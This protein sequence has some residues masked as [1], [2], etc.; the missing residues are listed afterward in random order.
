[1]R[2]GI[3]GQCYIY[4]AVSWWQ[5]SGGR[6]PLSVPGTHDFSGVT[7]HPSPSF[8]HLMTVHNS[9]NDDGLTYDFEK[10][11]T[12]DLQQIRSSPLPPGLKRL[13]KVKTARGI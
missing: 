5:F 10:Y 12:A 1:M 7:V 4:I 6:F 3:T 13:A 9:Y 2:D 8:P 11:V